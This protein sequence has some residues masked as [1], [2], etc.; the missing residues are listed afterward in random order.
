MADF[1]CV[2]DTINTLKTTLDEIQ[3]IMED[4]YG[5]ART[6]QAHLNDTKNWAGEAQLVGAAFLDIVVQYHGMFVPEED[7]PLVQAS[8]ALQDYLDRDAVFYENWSD[9]QD[10]E[11]I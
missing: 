5:K 1:K 10:L 6:V 3:T 2:T 4:T 9:Y 8:Q 7:G 11:D